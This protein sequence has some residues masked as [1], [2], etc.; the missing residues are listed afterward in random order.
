MPGYHDSKIAKLPALSDKRSCSPSA[1]RMEL[2]LRLRA[3]QAGVEAKER[4][5]SQVPAPDRP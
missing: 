5:A 1:M 4:V 3:S 2:D